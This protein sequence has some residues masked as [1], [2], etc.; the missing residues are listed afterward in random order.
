[1]LAAAVG[2][3]RRSQCA[4]VPS[5]MGITYRYMV[6]AVNAVVAI[7]RLVDTGNLCQLCGL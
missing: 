5:V 7:L 2:F 6:V 4:V 3:F 1:V